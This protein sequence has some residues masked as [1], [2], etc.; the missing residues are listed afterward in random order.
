[1]QSKTKQVFTHGSGDD[2]HVDDGG[3]AS[4][5]ARV[6]GVRDDEGE[7]V[8]HQ[9]DRLDHE[10]ADDAHRDYGDEYDP[11]RH[12]YDRESAFRQDATKHQLP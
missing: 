8:A 9:L 10:Y 4:A 11:V 5:H 1:M 3:Q 7:S 6:L 12:G 2:A